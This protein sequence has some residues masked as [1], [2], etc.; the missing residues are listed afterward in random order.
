MVWLRL[1]SIFRCGRIKVLAGWERDVEQVYR[2]TVIDQVIQQNNSHC[3]P[4]NERKSPMVVLL[5]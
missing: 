1:S 5:R 4:R 3:S 2:T